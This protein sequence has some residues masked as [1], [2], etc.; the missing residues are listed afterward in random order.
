MWVDPASFPAGQMRD[1]SVSR[2][3][4]ACRIRRWRRATRIV[5]LS[6]MD[7]DSVP[8]PLR[9]S[10]LLPPCLPVA[11]PPLPCCLPSPPPPPPRACLAGPSAGLRRKL[12]IASRVRL[13]ATPTVETLNRVRSKPSSRRRHAQG[14]PGPHLRRLPH[15]GGA[16]CPP[17]C[18]I[19]RFVRP[20]VPF[21]DEQEYLFGVL[22]RAGRSGAERSALV[23]SSGCEAESV[24]AGFGARN[25]ALW[26]RAWCRK[27]TVS[28]PVDNFGSVRRSVPISRR[29]PLCRHDVR[30]GLFRH[31]KRL[32]L[33]PV[34]P[35]RGTW[36]QAHVRVTPPRD[37]AL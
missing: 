11:F 31:P 20:P 4:C 6:E 17:S 2:G 12:R 10:N 34:I 15:A 3:L 21:G 24:D 1:F 23:S 5:S 7:S 27:R 32:V 30:N 29:S 35:R 19:R 37:C 33:V 13:C 26:R 9:L 8:G 28:A 36:G 16:P 22:R 25:G 14:R 18:F